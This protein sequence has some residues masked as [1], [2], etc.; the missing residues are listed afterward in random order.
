MSTVSN[1]QPQYL[2][3]A[4]LITDLIVWEGSI[5]SYAYAD[6]VAAAQLGGFTGLALTPS[7]FLSAGRHNKD[8]L[9]GVKNLAK[10]AGLS[11]H[12]DTVTGWAPIRVPTGADDALRDRFDHSVEAC[13]G[14][15]DALDIRSILAV[16]VFDHDAVAVDELVQGFGELCDIAAD[17][18]VA[19][20][21]EF[22]PFW[23]VPD[24]AAALRI[25]E[26][27]DRANSGLMLDT[28][29]FAHSGRDLALLESV[30]DW[31][32]HLQL[33][34]GTYATAGQ[35]L[36]EATL[37][38]RVLPGQ[39]DL[40]VLE[41]I[42]TVR[43]RGVPFT[44][45]PEVFSDALDRKPPAEAGRALGATTRAILGIREDGSLAG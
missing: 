42:E 21:L 13:I 26:E 10:D 30:L 29:H 3:P 16:A 8:G 24:L 11:L 40:A 39:G 25:V 19:V 37:H 1:S 14:L 5:R 36:I 41:V 4:A 43:G 6:Q 22:M 31:P 7:A 18:G 28:W 34:D 35:D 17:R 20:N 33:A 9:D 15:V 2:D 27:A 38:T 23:G 12:L 45:G 44:A 32:I